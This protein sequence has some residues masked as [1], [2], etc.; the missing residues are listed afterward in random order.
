VTNLQIIVLA[1]FPVAVYQIGTL[2]HFPLSGI[3]AAWWVILREVYS[4]E[5]TPIV[6]VSNSRLMMSDLP[7]ALIVSWLM[8]A[9]IHWYQADKKRQS[10][11]QSFRAA[12]AE[13][14]SKSEHN[15]RFLFRLYCSFS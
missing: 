11:L 12:Y 15:P 7:T 3:L 13:L 14:P 8:V 9:L 4:I 10:L 2:L 1:L 5:L 6:Q